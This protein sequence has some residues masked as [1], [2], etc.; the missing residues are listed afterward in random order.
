M[1]WFARPEVSVP[2]LGLASTGF[3]REL[4]EWATLC[5]KVSLGSSWVSAQD[6]YERQL[7]TCQ[8]RDSRPLATL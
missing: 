4:M 1:W 5:L 7:H 6:A 2:Q 8:N 3:C